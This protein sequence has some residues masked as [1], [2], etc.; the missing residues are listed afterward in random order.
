MG[1]KDLLMSDAG[2]R[3]QRHLSIQAHGELTLTLVQKGV[4]A[5]YIA[6]LLCEL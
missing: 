4:N 5:V 6:L 1:P 2:R 3:W